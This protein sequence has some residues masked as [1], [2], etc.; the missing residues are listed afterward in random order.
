MDGPTALGTV[1][2]NGGVASLSI[3]TLAPGNH[4]ISAS[5]SGDS[6]FL[7]SST[8]TP[9]VQL[10]GGGAGWHDVMT[11]DFL[12]NKKSETIG[13]TASGDWWVSVSNGSTVTNQLWT[14]WSPAVNWVDVQTGD[15]NGDG[16]TDIA[17]RDAASGQWWVALST[18]SSFTNSYWGSW[19]ASPAVTW[20]DVKVADFTGAVNPTTG[21]PIMD[22]TGRW[23]Q[24]G[25]WWTSVSNGS[26]FTTTM[27]TIWGPIAW[28][29]VQV[30]D[31]NGDKKADIVGRYAAGGE[32]WTGI[33]TGSSF[34]TSL[35]TRWAPDGPG[36][37]WVD[38]KVADFN[39]DGMADITGRWSQAGQWW[40]SIST[41]SGFITKLWTSWAP[42]GPAVTWVDVQVGDFDGDGKADIAGR[43]L[44]TG[45]WWTSRSIGSAFTTSMWDAW[46][47]AVTWVDVRVGDINGDGLP[48]LIGRIQQDGQWWAAV[49][50]ASAFANQFW[51]AWAV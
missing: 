11:G 17:G 28:S 23:A 9:L 3:S 30:G 21:D 12:G 27:W 32:W 20:A 39:G 16:K 37:T 22:I 43:W 2:L 6:M 48:D 1:P 36:I 10:V 26:A 29:D 15:F 49:S 38:V 33:S 4:S 7:P 35:W 31:F 24:T 14:S 51:T 40:T 5:F 8:S 25:Q 34:T 50:N 41:G 19:S 46:S 47:P 42:D 44:Q 13:M 45:Q 18:G